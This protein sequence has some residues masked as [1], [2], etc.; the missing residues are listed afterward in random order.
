MVVGL[1]VIGIDDQVIIVIDL[2]ECRF[3]GWGCLVNQVDNR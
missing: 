1:F 3:Y 2:V